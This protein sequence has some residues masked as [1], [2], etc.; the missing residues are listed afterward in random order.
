MVI[1]EQLLLN[2]GRKSITLSWI[3]PRIKELMTQHCQHS[4]EWLNKLILKINSVDSLIKSC[5]TSTRTK[6]ETLE[7]TTMEVTTT[8]KEET[9]L[10]NNK[11]KVSTMVSNKDLNKV[12]PKNN[13]LQWF[14][15]PLELGDKMT[16]LLKAS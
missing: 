3:G 12:Q 15:I 1:T 6:E 14:K 10:F 5:P 7:E 9:T 8:T 11:W 2:N 13:S 16:V 4:V